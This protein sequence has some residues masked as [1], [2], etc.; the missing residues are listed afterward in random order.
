VVYKVLGSATIGGM[1]GSTTS[2]CGVFHCPHCVKAGF[3]VF[4]SKAM[5]QLMK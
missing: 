3:I 1:V 4:M 5:K 2:T